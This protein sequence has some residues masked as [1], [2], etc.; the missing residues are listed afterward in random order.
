VAEDVGAIT[1][2][3]GTP[4][5]KMFLFFFS[6]YVSHPLT[7]NLQGEYYPNGHLVVYYSGR[8]NRVQTTTSVGW[9]RVSRVRAYHRNS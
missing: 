6:I 8:R 5:T 1:C 7:V 4:D 2:D 9:G 3:F